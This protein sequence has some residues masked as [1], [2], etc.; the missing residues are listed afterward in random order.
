MAE[1]EIVNPCISLEEAKH[2]ISMSPSEAASWVITEA[3][4]RKVSEHFLW[5]SALIVYQ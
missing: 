1:V 4:Y 5:Y 2:L 3:Y